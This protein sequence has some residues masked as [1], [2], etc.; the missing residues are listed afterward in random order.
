[1]AVMMVGVMARSF[2]SSS[3]FA[4]RWASASVAE[5]EAKRACGGQSSTPSLA[6]ALGAL[7]HEQVAGVEV[8]PAAM[9]HNALLE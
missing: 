3:F 4:E 6:H 5:E 8:G 2:C 9:N 7:G 1:M